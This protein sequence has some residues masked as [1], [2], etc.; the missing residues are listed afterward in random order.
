[1]KHW[2]LGYV[3][4]LVAC[5]MLLFAAP[6]PAQDGATS[7]WATAEVIHSETLLAQRELFAARRAENPAVHYDAAE[8]ALSRAAGLYA[9]RLQVDIQ[10]YAPAIDTEIILVLDT[11]RSAASTGDAAGLALQSGLLW[12]RLLHAAYTTT[13]SALEDGDLATAEA[14]LQLREY[15]QATKVTM[16]L[17]PAASALSDLRADRIDPA[18]AYEHIE[19]DLRDTYFFRLRTAFRQLEDAISKDFPIRAAE[20]SGAIEGYF[21]VMQDDFAAKLNLETSVAVGEKIDSLQRAVS[22]RDWDSAAAT[23][24]ETRSLL[25]NYQPVALSAD[26]IRERSQLLYI[27]TDLIYIEYRDGVRNG[28]ITIEIEYREAVT[29]REQAQSIYEE[30]RPIIDQNDANAAARLEILLSEMEGIML[31]LGSAGDLQARVD[32]AKTVISATLPLD[33]SNSATATFTIVNTLLTDI[34]NAIAGERYADA[35]QTRL[36]AYALFDFGV[37]QRLL[38]FSPELAARIESLF[39]HGDGTQPGLARALAL[40][41]DADEVTSILQT[42][43]GNLDEAQLVLGTGTSQPAT[44]VVNSAIIV[45]REG[46]EAVVIIAALTASMVR[47][48]VR[49]RTPLFVGAASALLA[50]TITWWIADAIL[51]LFSNNVELLEAIVSVIAIIMLLIITNWFFHKVYWVD[52][53][54]GFHKRKSEIMRGAAAGQFIGMAL[55]GFTSIYREGF[56]TVIFLQA[57]V[58]DSGIM[59]VLQGV[60]LGLLGVA[61]VGFVTLYLGKRL[62]YMTMMVFTGILIGG[63]LFIIVGKTVRVMQVVGWLPIAPIEGVSFPYWWGQWFGVYPTWQGAAAQFIVVLFVLG[64]YYI[65]RHQTTRQ[66]RASSAA[67][68]S[69]LS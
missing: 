11:A 20:W 8:E 23:I 33:L 29:F 3:G 32:E 28:E 12:T 40:R 4:V 39:W 13:L 68:A 53:L 2:I 6:V 1:M 37:E 49:F 58:L 44:I 35:E 59:I 9:D 67:Q 46:L 36:Q 48:N 42:L 34:D 21:G 57:L 66:R 5:S 17:D 62:P 61:V 30:L 24:D 22:A 55:L 27:F 63:V 25:T 26:D 54:A 47:A 64:S 50:T 16:I 41:A 15:R 56:E 51:R 60:G 31:E 14:W 45:F 18:T 38:A 43:Q 52:H 10:T 7:V 69:A 19:A 65:A